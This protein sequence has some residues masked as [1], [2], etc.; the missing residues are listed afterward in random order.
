MQIIKELKDGKLSSDTPTT[1]I[2]YA[3]ECA[4]FKAEMVKLYKPFGKDYSYLKTGVTQNWSPYG[5][6]P[7]KAK[8]GTLVLIE[9]YKLALRFTR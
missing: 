4:E 3:L 9:H 1:F 7:Q 5:K 8:L 6:D 2:K